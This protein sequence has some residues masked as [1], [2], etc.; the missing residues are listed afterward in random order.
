[1]IAS[2]ID[3]AKVVLNVRAHGILT[4]KGNGPL[5]LQA[6]GTAVRPCG[7]SI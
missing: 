1:M 4:K 2:G 3:A 6:D 5:F 7:R